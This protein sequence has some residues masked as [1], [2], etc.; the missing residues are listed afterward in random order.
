MSMYLPNPDVGSLGVEPGEFIDFPPTAEEV[1]TLERDV[2]PKIE[3]KPRPLAWA[4]F[5]SRA[6]RPKECMPQ[7]AP[8][9]KDRGAILDGCQPVL[10]F[11][12]RG[13]TAMH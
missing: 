2:G 11:G 12:R 3:S 7:R 1:G 9:L 6:V 5:V 8:C 13:T 10:G 4:F